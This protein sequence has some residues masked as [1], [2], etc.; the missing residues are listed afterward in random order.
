MRISHIIKKALPKGTLKRLS[1]FIYQANKTSFFKE[2]IYLR[3][4]S[5]NNLYADILILLSAAW[6]WICHLFIALK[7]KRSARCKFW[8]DNSHLP[9][10]LNTYR[11]VEIFHSLKGKISAQPHPALCTQFLD[12]Q[13]QYI[14]IE[15]TD[16]LY[17]SLGLCRNLTVQNILYLFKKQKVSWWEEIIL[18]ET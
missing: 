8:E 18:L 11:A 17:S 5:Y 1:S 12:R 10:T 4:K 16:L 9:D 3:G 15:K 14:A 2:T 13:E 7:L 6:R